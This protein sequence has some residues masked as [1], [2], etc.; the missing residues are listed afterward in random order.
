MAKR[1]GRPNL[2]PMIKVQMFVDK[3]QFFSKKDGIIEAVGYVDDY[4]VRVALRLDDPRAKTLI[5]H[6]GEPK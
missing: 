2:D 4:Q 5:K 3:I 6:F 1:K